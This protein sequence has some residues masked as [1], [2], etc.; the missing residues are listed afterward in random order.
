[1]NGNINWPG[2]V[3][4]VVVLSCMATIILSLMQLEKLSSESPR[5]HRRSLLAV[6][7]VAAVVGFAAL[8]FMPPKATSSLGAMG[9]ALTFLILGIGK[10]RIPWRR[11]QID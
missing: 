7:A 8:F 5:W 10:V 1:M 11:Q 6:V 4:L 3:A 9:G 2:V